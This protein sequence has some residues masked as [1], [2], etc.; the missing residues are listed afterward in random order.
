MSRPW[1][2]R[3]LGAIAAAA[4][5]AA[6]VAGLVVAPPDR[7]MGQV[8]RIM[9][10]HV[11]AAWSGFFA[12]FVVFLASIGY[13]LRNDYRLDRLA[14]AAA[15][16]GV[17]F[18]GLAILL[19]SLWGKPTWGVWWTWDPRLTSAAVL[20]A[21]YLGY[22]ALRAFTEDPRQRARWSAAVGIFG[23]LDV[24]IV[25]FSVLWWRTLHQPPSGPG[26]VAPSMLKVLGMSVAAF[27]L[28]LGY[29]ILSRYRLAQL[30]SDVEYLEVIHE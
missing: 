17:V 30:E 5:I 9:Y 12:F 2:I 20:M 11:P 24:P 18:M 3:L 25:Y 4:M 14:H 8:Q 16:V 26:T 29:L 21:V 19:G 22:L 13:L 27:T 6:L 1:F 7:V 15:E 28:L 23:F 10:V